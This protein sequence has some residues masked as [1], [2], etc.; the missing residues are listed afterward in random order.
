MVVVINSDE[1]S[2]VIVTHGAGDFLLSSPICATE[3]ETLAIDPLWGPP[4]L[5]SIQATCPRVFDLLPDPPP[6]PSWIGPIFRRP[7]LQACVASIDLAEVV[8]IERL[9]DRTRLRRPTIYSL[10]A[11]LRI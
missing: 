5:P 7:A 8:Y 2:I 4:Y 1:R 6:D 9:R 10:R 3:A 11:F